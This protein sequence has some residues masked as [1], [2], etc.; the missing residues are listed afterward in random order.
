M[1]LQNRLVAFALVVASKLVVVAF[2]LVVASD[3]VVLA[4]A[5]G[6]LWALSAVSDDGRMGQMDS[7]RV[8][9]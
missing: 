7:E 2:E 4:A 8:P 9:A 1:K 3:L 5:L 6:K